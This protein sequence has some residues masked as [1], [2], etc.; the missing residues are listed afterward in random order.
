MVLWY[1][2]G[3]CVVFAAKRNNGSNS[4]SLRPTIIVFVT[5]LKNMLYI[6]SKAITG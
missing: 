4:L 6:N 2:Y 1:D 5:L 3:L